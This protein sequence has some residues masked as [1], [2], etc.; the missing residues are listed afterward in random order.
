MWES[1][2]GVKHWQMGYLTQFEGKI[3]ANEPKSVPEK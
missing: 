1:F 2:E 3:L